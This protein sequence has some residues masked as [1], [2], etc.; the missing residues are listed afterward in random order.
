M[1]TA[2]EKDKFA[3]QRLDMMHQQLQGRG[4]TDQAVLE[5]MGKIPREE[6][7]PSMYQFQAYTDNPVPIGMGQTISQPYVTALMMQSLMLDD[8]VE[9]LEIGT[10]S[11]YQTAILA[12]TAK[13][14]YTIERLEQLSESA[15]AVL[16]RLGLKNIEFAIGDGTLGWRQRRTFERILISA[17]APAIPEPLAEELADGGVLV[18]PIGDQYSQQL[19][20]ARRLGSELIQTPVM[21][22]RFVNLVGKFGFEE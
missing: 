15:Q 5:A 4:I 11:G 12:S 17:G 7:I 20:V 9:V 22:V 19:T 21:S 14:V 3:L 1:V 6:F 16:G 10:G 18:A 2:N 8:S 13:K